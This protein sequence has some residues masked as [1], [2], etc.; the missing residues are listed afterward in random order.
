M[1]KKT[2]QTQ[3]TTR[4]DRRRKSTNAQ[5]MLDLLES[6][7]PAGVTATEIARHLFDRDD[8]DAR[9]RVGR[10]ARTLRKWGFRAHGFGG[11]YNLCDRDPQRLGIVYLCALRSLSGWAISAGN[12]ADGIRDAGDIAKAMASR[13]ELKQ[14]LRELAS[15]L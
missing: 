13:R 12:T 10:T 9:E 3:S 14:A 4:R 15:N 8:K 6:R 1:H 7:F 2:S 5:K 11:V